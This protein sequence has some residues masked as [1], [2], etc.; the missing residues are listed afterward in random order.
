MGI[1]DFGAEMSE[2]GWNC[3]NRRSSIITTV[4]VWWA[5]ARIPLNIS[6]GC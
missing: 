3:G 4:N 6:I 2:S 5:S 1:S